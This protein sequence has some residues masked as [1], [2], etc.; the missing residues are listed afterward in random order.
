M[1]SPGKNNLFQSLNLFHHN[2]IFYRELDDYKEKHD[3]NQNG[4]D[5]AK[6]ASKHVCFYIDFEFVRHLTTAAVTS[7][8]TFIIF[9]HHVT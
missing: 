4:S 1:S 3:D 6:I 7:L 8:L 5:A 9:Y 2:L